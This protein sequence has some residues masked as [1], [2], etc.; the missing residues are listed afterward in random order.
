MSQLWWKKSQINFQ[1]LVKLVIEPRTLWFE[2]KLATVV[3]LKINQMYT[4][5]TFT[6]LFNF[7]DN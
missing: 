5:N 2:G 1:T 3:Y 6:F 4:S 7:S